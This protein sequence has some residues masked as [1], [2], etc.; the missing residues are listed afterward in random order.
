MTESKNA[1]AE[2]PPELCDIIL[3]PFSIST[4]YSYTFIPSLMH[5]LESLLVAVNLKKMYSDHCKQNVDIPLMK[6]I[7]SGSNYAKCFFFFWNYTDQTLL[8]GRY[9]KQ[10]LQ[11][12]AKRNFIWNP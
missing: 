10:L 11:R 2:L 1:H 8:Y 3:S 7:Y 12:S 4:L 6:V 9:W 5:R